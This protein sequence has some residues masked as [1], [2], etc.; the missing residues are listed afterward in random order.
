MMLGTA[1]PT[2]RPVSSS[3][4]SARHSGLTAVLICWM[5]VRSIWLH[6]LKASELLAWSSLVVAIWAPVAPVKSGRIGFSGL[7][8]GTP[9]ETRS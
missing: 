5:I 2:R 1:G 3:M 8:K 4:R 6:I 7:M 9:G